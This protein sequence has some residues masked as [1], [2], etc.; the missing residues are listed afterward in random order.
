MSIHDFCQRTAQRWHFW[1][2]STPQLLIAA[3]RWPLEV[4]LY[5]VQDHFVC[6][7][8]T[9]LGLLVFLPF[10]Q[11]LF[12]RFVVPPHHQTVHIVAKPHISPLASSFHLISTQRSPQR[13][14]FP[15]SVLR[16]FIIVPFHPYTHL[17]SAI[18]T[19]LRNRGRRSTSVSSSRRQHTATRWSTS[20]LKLL[21]GHHQFTVPYVL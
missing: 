19:P 5:V 12:P 10:F 3:N 21:N 14:S 13:S 1:Q 11:T 2:K 18:T 9:S 15:S 17:Y 4:K 6:S 7:I 16:S 8:T 20:S